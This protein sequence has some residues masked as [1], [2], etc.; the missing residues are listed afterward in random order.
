LKGHGKFVAADP[1]D[2]LVRARDRL[3]A[4][5]Q[6]DQQLVAV[7]VSVGVV[8]QLEAVHVD[9]QQPGRAASVG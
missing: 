7:A 3:K 8:D 6:G 4:A 2:L 9:E 1:G 5:C